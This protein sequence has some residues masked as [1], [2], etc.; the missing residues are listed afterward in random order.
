MLPHALPTVNIEL[1]CNQK[2][3]TE[4]FTDFDRYCRFEQWNGSYDR[5]KRRYFGYYRFKRWDNRFFY[6]NNETTDAV[7][8]ELKLTFENLSFNKDICN[9][10]SSKCKDTVNEDRVLFKRFVSFYYNL[11]KTFKGINDILTHLIC[12]NYRKSTENIACETEK[13]KMRFSIGKNNEPMTMAFDEDFKG[14][15]GVWNKFLTIINDFRSKANVMKKVIK[16][17]EAK[18]LTYQELLKKLKTT[19][20]AA[21]QNY[22]EVRVRVFF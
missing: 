6:S 12:F 3:E 22:I 2:A 13:K 8:D 9:D 19:N 10:E 21:A 14:D 5:F 7:V 11:N 4:V 18:I 1:L 15:I 16:R 20:E 17:K